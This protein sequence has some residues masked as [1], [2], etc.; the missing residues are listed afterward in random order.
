MARALLS[1][2]E[3]VLARGFATK[4]VKGKKAAPS[5]ARIENKLG[6]GLRYRRP[7]VWDGRGKAEGKEY[8]PETVKFQGLGFKGALLRLRR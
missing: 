7:R 5:A 6:V 4:I 8:T 3:S 1:N 2:G